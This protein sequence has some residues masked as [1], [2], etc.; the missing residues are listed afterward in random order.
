[1]LLFRAL[2]HRPFA[3][4]WTGQTISRLGDHI[5]RIALAWWVLEQTGSAAAMGTVLIFATLPMLLFLLIGGV[6]VDR[7]SRVRVMIASDALRAI[8]VA[9]VAALAFARALE[10][11]HILIASVAFGFVDAF[12]QPAYVAL[13]PEITPRDLLPSANSLTSLSGRITGIV[14]PGVGAA[15]V[16]LGGTPTAFALDALSFF[17]SAVCL[18]P[19]I[20]LS[21]ARAE[22]STGVLR[23]LREGLAAVFASPWLWVTIVIFAFANVT[24]D[25]PI[26]V[27]LPLLVKNHLRADVGGLGMLY[28]ASA[29]GSILAALY[30]GRFKRL[31]R[32]GLLLY[33]AAIVAALGVLAIGLPI[34]IYG[35]AVAILVFGFCV[36]F[37]GLVWTNTLQEMVPRD[38]LGRVS[39]VDWL[40]SG[41][42]LPIG[43]GL[44]GWVADSI[45]AANVF[46]IGGAVSLV[47][48]SL[49]LLHPQV[50]AVD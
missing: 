19:I 49:G 44:T 29:L 30:L 14:G 10:L 40:G 45:G 21:S 1:M 13:V 17:L 46:L 9:M 12:F 20:G 23:D 27:A 3:F 48:V 15:I 22:K 31:R 32:R 25:G 28:S 37:L 11:W 2:T 6:A 38:L 39:S 36:A 50:R 26:S 8:V 33:G 47:L 34:T 18:V 4:L 43:Y 5:H 16:A 7:F 41:A 35:V 42:L 24:L